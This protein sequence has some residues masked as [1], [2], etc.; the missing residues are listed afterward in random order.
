MATPKVTITVRLDPVL[1]SQ[2]LTKA[3]DQGISVNQLIVDLLGG[4]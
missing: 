4:K 2:L 1:Y 3:K